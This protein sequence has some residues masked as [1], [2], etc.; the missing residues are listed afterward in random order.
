VRLA[1]EPRN[2]SV[3][4][5]NKNI[6]SSARVVDERDALRGLFTM[7]DEGVSRARSILEGRENQAGGG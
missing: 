5:I 6:D 3:I 2:W 7:T 1:L 4:E